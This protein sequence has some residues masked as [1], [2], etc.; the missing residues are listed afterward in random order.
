MANYKDIKGFHVQ[1]LSTD[2]V[3]NTGSGGSWSSAPNMNTARWITTGCAE[4]YTST[5]TLAL[6]VGGRLGP[7]SYSALNE[8]YNG[9]SWTEKGDL[10]SA[11]DQLGG[12]GTTTSGLVAG[13]YDGSVR[14][15]T[16]SWNGSSWTEKN[17][18][19]TARYELGSAGAS[20]SSALRWSGAPSKTET[21]S[22]DGT[23]WTELNDVN[24]QAT[25][26]AG[27]GT[28]T[29]ALKISGEAPTP[30]AS[31]NVEQWNG[32]SWT[33]G[34]NVNAARRYGVGAGDVNNALFYGGGP[35]ATAATEIWNG[36]SW[37][38]GGDLSTAVMYSGG[39]GNNG[40]S[41][42]INYGGQTPP[43]VATTEIFEITPITANVM[44]LGQVYFNSSSTN[45]FK[46]TQQSAPTGTWS[47]GGSLNT[48]R[49]R[50]GG[51]VN[52]TQ[53]AGLV[54]GSS[55]SPSGQ[56]EEYNGT[57]WSEQNDMNEG[58]YISGGGAGT[59]TA[60]VT[61][62]GYDPA[63]SPA[64]QT[65]FSETYNG[66][67]WTEGNN[68]NEGRIDCS[69]FGTSTA[70]VLVGGGTGPGGPN[71]VDSVETYNGTSWTETT[72]IPTVTQEMGSLGV[73][74]A[75]LI[76]GGSVD[77]DPTTKNTTVEWDGT[78]W[79]SGGTYPINIKYTTGFG[80]LTNG[81]G[82]GGYKYPAAYTGVCNVYNGTSWTEVAELTTA[83]LG[84]AGGGT[85]TSGLVA[86][87]ET[88][89][90]A[91][92]VTEEWTVPLSNKTIT[93]S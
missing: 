39:G 34:N 60:C 38:E 9:S 5:A 81:I 58:R 62:G 36:S 87:G 11:R 12:S 71:T 23:S 48:A 80:S 28:Q 19:N 14:G 69:T 86:G 49:L 15:Y 70:G 43:V 53:N 17:D 6:C 29:A 1:S 91:V 82:A 52:A 51:A 40:S 24:T 31:V 55:T 47:S 26:P 77:S 20:A 79:T 93:L 45:A 89:P 92:A 35:S 65:V 66:T 18:L 74:T 54:F 64:Y 46:V 90:G 32:T 21:E 76:Y 73:S 59:Q 7:G 3:A 85:G 61:A 68:L 2:T 25:A 27:A 42:A 67:S 50:F 30:G 33:E 56:T 78:S 84:T 37:T 57:A 8:E 72:N 4:G 88:A 75:G 13:G 63:S 22:F 16:E 83:R 10:N 41:S 44:N